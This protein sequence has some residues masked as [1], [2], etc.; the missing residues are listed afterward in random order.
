L[1]VLQSWGLS[2]FLSVI[3]LWMFWLRVWPLSQ[4]FLSFIWC[5][6]CGVPFCQ[7]IKGCSIWHIFRSKIIISFRLF[8][9][10]LKMSLKSLRRFECRKLSFKINNDWFIVHHSIHPSI[11]WIHNKVLSLDQFPVRYYHFW[12]LVQ[13]EEVLIE[14]LVRES[15]FFIGRMV[16]RNW[17]QNLFRNSSLGIHR[18]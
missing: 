1:N 16:C 6:I 13:V 5:S 12:V 14:R 2:V 11:I 3:F 18:I 15:H 17:L 8:I 9:W 4:S 10:I 7:S